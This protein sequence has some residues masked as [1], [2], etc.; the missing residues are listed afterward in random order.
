MHGDK[1]RM[2]IYSFREPVQIRSDPTLIDLGSI[3]KEEWDF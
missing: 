2:T 3:L 1:L